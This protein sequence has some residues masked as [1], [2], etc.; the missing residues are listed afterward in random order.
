MMKGYL[1]NPEEKTVEVVEVGDGIDD[2]KTHIEASLFDVVRLPHNDAIYVDDEGLYD[3]HDYFAIEGYLNPLAG[4]GLV[5]GTD[6]EGESTDPIH[7]LMDIA[8]MVKFISYEQAL[9]MAKLV[10]A[11]GAR[12]ER[13]AMT[14]GGSFAFIHFPITGILEDARYTDKSS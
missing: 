12:R 3:K 4:R 1:I 11:E 10:D 8:N 9:E 14:T 7:E 6:S 13:E 5:L 2:I